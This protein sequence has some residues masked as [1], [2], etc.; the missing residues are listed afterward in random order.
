M[1][2]LG[3]KMIFGRP[4]DDGA[5]VVGA[6]VVGLT[7]GVCCCCV[8]APGGWNGFGIPNGF[9]K[10]GNADGM[11]RVGT[12]GS[13]VGVVVGPGL[14]VVPGVV[15]CGGVAT[16]GRTATGGGATTGVV[17][18]VAGGSERTVEAG[19]IAIGTSL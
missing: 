11:I 9:G 6:G 10:L 14:G 4:V 12:V 18:G 19:G 8:G 17:P 1:P 16:G 7:G 2:Y 13:V 3:E 15:G 5:G